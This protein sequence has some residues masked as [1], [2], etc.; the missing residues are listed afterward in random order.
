MTAPKNLAREYALHFTSAGAHEPSKKSL[1][2]NHAR[3]R[4]LRKTASSVAVATPVVPNGNGNGHA[5]FDEEEDSHSHP[6]GFFADQFEVSTSRPDYQQYMNVGVDPLCRIAATLMHILTELVLK[7][8]GR[9]TEK[10]LVSSLALVSPL[11]VP[12]L[13]II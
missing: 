9:R 5:S 6:R 12:S 4:I 10:S 3:P 2:N 7:S 13:S 11:V 8:G 1:V